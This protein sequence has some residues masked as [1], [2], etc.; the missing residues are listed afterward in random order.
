MSEMASQITSFT[1]IYSTVYS[2]T[3]KKNWKL[4]VVFAR[5]IYWW[6]SGPVTRKMSPFDGVIMHKPE[7]N[8]NIL[9]GAVQV[10]DRPEL[11]A[12]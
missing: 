12:D 11:E 10:T 8:A 5:G 3:Y 1:I 9:V 4:C 6:H 2:G 7:P